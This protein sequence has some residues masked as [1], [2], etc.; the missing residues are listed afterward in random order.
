[1]TLAQFQSL[2]AGMPPSTLIHFLNPWGELEPAAIVTVEDLIP[3]DP[4]RD[5]FPAGAIVI[6]GDAD[7]TDRSSLP[8]QS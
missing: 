5:D 6:T 4:L 8:A 3:G 1:M 2:T 7:L